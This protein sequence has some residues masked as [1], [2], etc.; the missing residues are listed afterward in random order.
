MF[1]PGGVRLV[2]RGAVL[3]L[4]AGAIAF[5]QIQGWALTTAESFGQDSSLSGIDPATT[6]VARRVE[7][8]KPAGPVARERTLGGNPL[9]SVPLS[10]LSATRER[11]IF[12]PSRRPPH[13][14]VIAAPYVPPVNP[15]PSKP[16]E[17]DH[18]L[19][20]V[21]G[22]VA[23]ETQG[24]GIFIDQIDKTPMHLKT[25]EGHEGW[26]LRS[27]RGREVIFEKN[28]RTATLVLPPPGS[29][30]ETLALR[31]PAPVGN[32]WR[33]GD[34]QMI[35]PPPRRASFPGAAAPT[36]AGPAAVN[37]RP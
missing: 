23:G 33:D 1:V 7:P 16:P 21:L 10:S 20:T 4:A 19:L 14:P 36:V 12:S 28:N 26:V 25:G 37:R 30:E 32:T 27:V 35:S 2:R 6:V 24:I 3:A 34:G 5:G 15:P 17:P 8:V 11:P 29:A 9:W 31:A 18:P 13:A 22:T